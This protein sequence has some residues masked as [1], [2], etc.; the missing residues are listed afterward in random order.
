MKLL[1]FGGNSVSVFSHGA[2]FVAWQLTDLVLLLSP[3]K[4]SVD[5]SVADTTGAVAG[6]DATCTA[7]SSSVNGTWHADG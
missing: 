2:T 7:C 6:I 1:K 3:G 4:A 5:T